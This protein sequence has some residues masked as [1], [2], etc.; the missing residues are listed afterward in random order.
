MTG[1][2][3]NLVPDLLQ[4]EHADHARAMK[5]LS[6]CSSP[7]ACSLFLVMLDGEPFAAW[8]RR[9]QAEVYASGFRS[10]PEIVEG[11]FTANR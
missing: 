6:S 2:N 1:F 7:S 9:Q 10:S 4:K 3:N 5:A 8:P 11:T